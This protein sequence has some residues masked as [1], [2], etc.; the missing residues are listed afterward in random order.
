MTFVNQ[1]RVNV[2][3]GVEMLYIDANNL[4]GQ[5]LS[6]RLPYKDFAWVED[7]LEQQSILQTLPQMDVFNSDLGYVLE[8]DI[9][10]P[11]SFHD[12]LDDLPLAPENRIVQDPTSYMME[13]WNLIEEEKPFKA[14]RK[15]I[16]SHLPKEHYVVHFALLKFF[17]EMGA[18]VRKVHRVVQFRQAAFFEP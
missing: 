18:I 11:S 2:G 12:L 14:G 5:A 3:P 6:M 1:H 15:L 17:I 13:L 8:C 16:L 4:Y 7:T 10:I 9:V